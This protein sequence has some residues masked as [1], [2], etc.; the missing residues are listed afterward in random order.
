VILLA[1]LFLPVILMLYVAIRVAAT[2]LFLAI[3]LVGW[4]VGLLLRLATGRRDL[5][6]RPPDASD[7]ELPRSAR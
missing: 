1:A 7:D 4:V 3:L 2:L 5:E 6:A